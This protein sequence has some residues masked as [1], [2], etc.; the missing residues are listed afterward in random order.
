MKQCN[1]TNKDY[2]YCEDCNEYVDFWK[3]DNVEDT[4]HDECNWHY[5]NDEE[6]KD[7]IKDCEEDK[8]FEE[9]IL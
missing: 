7:C 3:Y 9:V 1:K 4:G 8:C 6:L 2:I 5:V